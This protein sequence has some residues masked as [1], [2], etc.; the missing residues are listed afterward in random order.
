MIARAAIGR[1]GIIDF[2]RPGTN[3]YYCVPYRFTEA[4][5]TVTKEVG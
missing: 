3:H 4:D 2:T 1:H 5:V